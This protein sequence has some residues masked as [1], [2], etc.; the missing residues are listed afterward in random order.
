MVIPPN[1]REDA[2]SGDSTICKRERLLRLVLPPNARENAES[3]D[4]TI[5]K[6][7]C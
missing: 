2:Q 7:D 6:R 4:S 3:G 5:C 1:A